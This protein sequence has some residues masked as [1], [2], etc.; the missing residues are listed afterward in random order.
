MRWSTD[1]NIKGAALSLREDRALY[2]ELLQDGRGLALVN[3]REMVLPPGLVHGDHLIDGRSLG[4][5]LRRQ[6]RF[7]WGKLPLA[8]GVPSSDFL[9]KTVKL[10]AGD[11]SEAKSALRWCF[12]DFFPL[13]YDEALFDVS[14]LPGRTEGQML[15]LGTACQKEE[16]TALLES[17]KSLRCRVSVAEPLCVAC[18]RAF[19][20][21]DEEAPVVMVVGQDALLHLV[22]LKRNAAWMFRTLNCSLK[23][24]EELNAEVI[25]TLSY[26]RRRFAPPSLR[27]CKAGKLPDGAENLPVLADAV[28]RPLQWAQKIRWDSPREAEWFD[29][30]GLLMRWGREN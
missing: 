13:A 7:C 8:L 27:L 21:K 16:L 5:C 10:P 22:F 26:I 23:S 28:Q 14:E 11:L 20:L 6:L 9:F 4:S 12:S 1:K 24:V 17:L 3:G 18:A 30:M 15:L 25:D 2:A 29:V 19:A